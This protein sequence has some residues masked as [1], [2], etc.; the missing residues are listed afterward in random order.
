MST[1]YADYDAQ[2]LAT[3]LISA[4]RA[5]IDSML[6][7]KAT[8]Y[9][10]QIQ[11]LSSLDSYLTEFQDALEDYTDS[12]STT[13]FSAQTATVSDDDYY[14]VTSDG[15]AATG[16]YY[17][18]VKQ[19]A[20]SSQTALTFTDTSL[21]ETGSLTFTV[22]GKSTSIDMSGIS[23]LSDLVTQINKD[24]NNP[25][26][27]ASLI[28]SGDSTMLL[29]T[30]EN[31]G[32]KYDVG[33]TYTGDSSSTFSQALSNKSVLSKAQD[34]IIELGAT[35]KVE[36]TSSSNTLE[37]VVDGLT[38]KLI[39][40]QATDADPIRT[41]VEVDNS[42]VKDN[43]NTFISTYNTLVTNLTKLY[44]D[45]GDLEG[46]STLRTIISQ[47]K[48]S[49]RNSLPS[50]YTLDSL[51]LKFTSKG[52]LEVDSTTLT[53]ALAKDPDILNKAFT[54][55]NSLFDTIDNLLKSYTKTGGIIS[56]I[57]DSTQ[58]SLDRVTDRQDAYD[59]K[60]K[61]LYTIYLN[62]FISMKT[63][64]AQMQSSLSTLSSSSS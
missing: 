7:T 13:S 35:N 10:T 56:D 48:D 25:G 63:A 40:A 37:N 23:S 17:I 3:A 20:Q 15:S 14:S 2:S 6:S 50:G 31:T 18:T 64:L 26:V 52:K 28:K 5:G 47:L 12:S 36:I 44:D 39:K 21:S 59:K 60:M 34:A 32:A 45:G 55:K 30:S 38:I 57:Q 33:M 61:K 46:N 54:D 27:T 11:G 53:S 8:K 16:N 58:D 41:T 62:Q 22:N 43:L 51:G 1:S 9:N 4:D 19:I 24:S 49:M 29:L 42:T